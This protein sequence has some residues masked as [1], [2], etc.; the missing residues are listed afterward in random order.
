MAFMAKEARTVPRETGFAFHAC[1]PMRWGKAYR[2]GRGTTRRP[3]AVLPGATRAPR[4]QR[5]VKSACEPCKTWRSSPQP[6]DWET[7]RAELTLPPAPRIKRLAS[8]RIRRRA[9][10]QRPR[11]AGIRSRPLIRK[12]TSRSSQGF[13]TPNFRSV[14]LRNESVIELSVIME[15]LV[16][17]VS[18]PWLA[19]HVR[20]A[21]RR[22]QRLG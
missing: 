15:G 12:I 16:L 7:L 17:R 2:N 4:R 19:W 10:P 8:Q 3:T 11:G 1:D 6:L 14:I 18:C 20:C 13:R 9:D 5:D 21:A 22:N